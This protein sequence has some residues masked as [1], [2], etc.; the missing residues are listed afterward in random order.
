MDSDEAPPPYS[1]VDPLLAPTVNN[2]DNNASAETARTFLR[3]RGGE[4]SLS[5]IASRDG[6]A[7]SVD[8]SSAASFA[9]PANFA[10]ATAYF[11]ERPP[12]HFD[13]ERPA[14]SHL[15][16]IYPRSQSKD[17]PRRP[18]CWSPRT[19]EITQQD[20]DMFLKYLFPPHLGLAASSAH[21]PRQLRAEIQRDRKD[22]PQETDEQR[23]LRIAAVIEE[24]NE[25]FFG[26]RA[27]RIEFI[28]VT[29]SEN[30]PV[31]PL[32]PRCY[33]AATKASRANRSTQA[34]EAG[35]NS[36]SVPAGMLPTVAGQPTAPPASVAYA[37]GVYPYPNPQM[38]PAP[39]PPYGPPAFFPPGIVPNTPPPPPLAYPYP[40][41]P[42][43]Q[44]QQP[45]SWG[46]NNRPYGPQ[47]QYSSTSKA[48]PFGWLS[49]L[50]SHAQKYSERITEQ[51]QHYGRQVEEQAMAH[52]RWIEEQAGLRSRKLEDVFSGLSSPPRVE[53]AANN[54]QAQGYCTNGYGYQP[55]NVVSTQPVT[56]PVTQPARRTSVGSVSSESS[57]SSIDSISTTSDLS[58]SDLATVRAQL[59]S[60]NNHHDRELYEAAVGLRRQLDVLRESRRQSR[61][62]GRGRW[63]NG[64]GHDGQQGLG[65]GGWGRWESPQEQQ[66]SSAERRALK[67]EVRA[68][69][70]A[71]K[72][73]FRRARDEQRERRR[74]KRNRW[75][76]ERR[77]RQTS[78]ENEHPPET[79]LEQRLQ[80][81]E[82]SNSQ[83]RGTMVRIGAPCASPRQS[84]SSEASGISSINTPSTGSDGG[85]RANSS[86]R[87]GEAPTRVKTEESKDGQKQGET[88]KGNSS[89]PSKK[90]KGSGSNDA[91]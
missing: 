53:Y 88:L 6:S 48:G 77:S 44:Y 14:L 35:E 82:L 76:Q 23:Q 2:R 10:S 22:R 32:C 26:P 9:L 15:L 42:P 64:W 18:R 49:S 50:A 45:S 36:A 1:A 51:A 33:P 21:L 79:P 67:E 68:T 61:I 81:L 74:I 24:W 57:F 17:F 13:E 58:S 19:A 7:A 4:A 60:L 5:D 86:V 37:T 47:Y 83:E 29:E 38:P 34:Q 73:V 63:R 70:K 43:S 11:I 56:T 55:V 39:Y 90:D 72:D 40:P 59:Q 52:G 25:C 46:W 31:S 66:R 71:F 27:T 78:R 91:S 65:R 54:P 41:Q 84:L 75:R 3:L 16:T 87:R 8:G 69:K 80:N 89:S 20:W 85:S 62:S 28:Y 12:T 30:A